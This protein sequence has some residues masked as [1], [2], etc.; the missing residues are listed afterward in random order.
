MALCHRTRLTQSQ[1]FH[2]RPN[3]QTTSNRPTKKNGREATLS[4]A[5]HTCHPSVFP[6]RFVRSDCLHQSQRVAQDGVVCKVCFLPMNSHMAGV[7]SLPR[8]RDIQ[9]NN[10]MAEGD[11]PPSSHPPAKQVE[12]G[13]PGAQALKGMKASLART[14]SDRDEPRETDTSQQ[15]RERSS[16]QLAR[17]FCRRNGS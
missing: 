8:C 17:Q 7:H 11:C 16:C 1:P 10:N 5:A 6:A 3:Q 9:D 13:A 4:P 12:A 2:V 14:G 15:E